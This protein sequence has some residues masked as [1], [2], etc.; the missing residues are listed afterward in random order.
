MLILSRK[1]DELIRINSNIVVKIIAISDNQVKIGIEAPSD[2]VVLRGEIYEKVKLS[3]IEA[4]KQSSQTK[5][6]NLQKLAV[7]KLRNKNE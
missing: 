2:V 7:N 3:T 1:T 4:A 6:I 5:N